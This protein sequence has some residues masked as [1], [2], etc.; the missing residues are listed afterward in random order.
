MSFAAVVRVD[1]PLERLDDHLLAMRRSDRFSVQS[2]RDIGPREGKKCSPHML[3]ADQVDH[4]DAGT[5]SP[6]SAQVWDG[7]PVPFSNASA[8]VAAAGPV[9]RGKRP[10]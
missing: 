9:A 3:P 2:R 8:R 6:Q 4:H 7:D 1:T 5:A 10:V